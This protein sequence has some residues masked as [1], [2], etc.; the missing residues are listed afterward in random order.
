MA[1]ELTDESIDAAIERGSRLDG[2]FPPPQ[3]RT[4]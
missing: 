2:S 3:F 1:S 4:L